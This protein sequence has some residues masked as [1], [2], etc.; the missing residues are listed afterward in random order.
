MIAAMTEVI[1]CYLCIA[2]SWRG[3]AAAEEV[4]ERFLVCAAQFMPALPSL[5]AKIGQRERRKVIDAMPAFEGIQRFN[6]TYEV[7]DAVVAAKGGAESDGQVICRFARGTHTPRHLTC[8]CL[9]A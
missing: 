5:L 8:A 1:W 9:P 7:I 2:L 3:E 4:V 6:V